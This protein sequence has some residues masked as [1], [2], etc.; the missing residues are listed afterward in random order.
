MEIIFNSSLGQRT[1]EQFFSLSKRPEP[2]RERVGSVVLSTNNSARRTNSNTSSLLTNSERNYKD[3][4][5]DKTTEEFYNFSDGKEYNATYSYSQP[6]LRAEVILTIENPN[7]NLFSIEP[8]ELT[9]NYFNYKKPQKVT[10]TLK[11]RDRYHTE[12]YRD[13][14]IKTTSELDEYYNNNE[15]YYNIS[16]LVAERKIGWFKTHETVDQFEFPSH[17]YKDK[18]LKI[19]KLRIVGCFVNMLFYPEETIT[20]GDKVYKKSPN[21]IKL[22]ADALVGGDAPIIIPGE[23]PEFSPV[24]S[25]PIKDP[26]Y[27]IIGID[28]KILETGG[29][30]TTTYDKTKLNL[31]PKK[32]KFIISDVYS[33]EI[34]LNEFTVKSLP[35]KNFLNIG[36][37]SNC[38]VEYTFSPTLELTAD[39][40]LGNIDGHDSLF[41]YAQLLD[42]SEDPNKIFTTGLTLYRPF[43]LQVD[44][45]ITPNVVEAYKSDTVL[46]LFSLT[47]QNGNFKHISSNFSQD[48]EI[49]IAD[50]TTTGLKGLIKYPVKQ[51]YAFTDS[52]KHIDRSSLSINTSYF[53]TLLPY[54]TE[55]I[56]LELNKIQNFFVATTETDR[57]FKKFKE[58]SQVA[59]TTLLPSVA[60]NS[61]YGPK[62]LEL[63]SSKTGE[64]YFFNLDFLT[65]YGFT[66]STF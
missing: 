5:L 20:L 50:K 32:M 25:T 29:E 10:F 19:S 55:Q 53:T 62:M 58:T 59:A 49:F 26:A 65:K 39:Q 34:N 21:I 2:F 44:A 66:L 61:V 12:Y 48:A 8:Q 42:G 31:F 30:Y 54:S 17:Y 6:D 45:E 46:H 40:F 57:T 35:V 24:S 33:K 11:E 41:F 51:A 23:Y 15:F 22:I 37:L 14:K 27:D 64:K 36:P 7:S 18:K 60:L 1:I 56:N 9:F 3:Q 16:V 13:I 28:G 52:S 4:T 38:V 47:N 43:Q 63:T